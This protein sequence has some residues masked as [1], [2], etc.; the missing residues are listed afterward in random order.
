MVLVNL[1]KVT[2]SYCITLALY[3]LTLAFSLT[4]SLCSLTEA[5]GGPLTWSLIIDLSDKLVQYCGP[6]IL[7]YLFPTSHTSLGLVTTSTCLHSSQYVNWLYTL[8]W[9]SCPLTQD[10]DE[11]SNCIHVDSSLS[12]TVC[13]PWAPHLFSVGSGR[14]RDQPQDIAFT[15]RKGQ[16]QGW[17]KNSSRGLFLCCFRCLLYYISCYLLIIL[18]LLQSSEWWGFW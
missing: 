17:G 3:I 13:R 16:V 8:A 12:A 15:S 10:Q 9:V 2:L 11:N 7:K 18:Y 4:L 1:R 5:F 6:L 14:R